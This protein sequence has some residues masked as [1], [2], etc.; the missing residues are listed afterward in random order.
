MFEL[1]LFELLEL[2]LFELCLFECVC[3]SRWSYLGCVRLC[4]VFVWV[5]LFV[6]YAYGSRVSALRSL[7]LL[8][9][10]APA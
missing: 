2:C 3:S 6:L 9:T 7:D 5:V 8:L 4:C 10:W 1:W